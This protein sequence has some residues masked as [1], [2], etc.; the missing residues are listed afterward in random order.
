M[1]PG[2]ASLKFVEQ[3]HESKWFEEQPSG[4]K[5]HSFCA[6]YGTTEVVP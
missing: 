5:A 1:N 4:A 6:I 3:F 2:V